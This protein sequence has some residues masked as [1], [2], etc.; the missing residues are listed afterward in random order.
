MSDFTN[1][2][3]PVSR[4]HLEEAQYF[5]GVCN[6]ALITATQ[7]AADEARNLSAAVGMKPFVLTPGSQPTPT[8]PKFVMEQAST[9]CNPD[10]GF[11]VLW[12]SGTTGPPK[13]VLL[14]RRSAYLAVQAYQKA[15]GLS[16]E[17]TWLHQ[18]PANWKGGFDF[19]TACIYS[20]TCL[21]FCAGAFSPLWFWQRMQQ[22]G[23]TCA[24]APTPLLDVLS[25]S[26]DVVRNTRPLSEYEQAI[27][28][29]RDLRLLCTGSMRVPESVKSFWREL[30]GGRPLVN[31]YGTTEVIGMISMMDWKSDTDGP[32]VS[33]VNTEMK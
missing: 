22:G 21:E 8:H 23:I 17:D 5:F 3:V 29:L 25:E 32:A 33:I 16:P 11:V 24:V 19:F 7:A 1:Y 14:S 6:F 10:K 30:R 28:G 26:L 27:Q 20:G 15:L 13:G 31:L 18:S 4:I 12:T 2:P 9:P